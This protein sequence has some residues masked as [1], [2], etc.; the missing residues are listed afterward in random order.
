M[1]VPFKPYS[2]QD[3]D[4]FGDFLLL[5]ATSHLFNPP[6][7][8]DSVLEVYAKDIVPRKLASAAQLVLFNPQEVAT[9]VGTIYRPHRDLFLNSHGGLGA[10]DV[11]ASSDDFEGL[12]ACTNANLTASGAAGN[13]D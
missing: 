11:K 13:F 1:K 10:A 12:V 2:T 9:R 4:L 6:S 5:D 3:R 7:S 8:L